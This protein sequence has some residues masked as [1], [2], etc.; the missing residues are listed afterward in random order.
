ML[1]RIAYGQILPIFERVICPSLDNG[2]VL[3]FHIFILCMC[4]AFT[5]DQC[6]ITRHGGT[7]EGINNQFIICRWPIP[8]PSTLRLLCLQGETE[9]FFFFLVISHSCR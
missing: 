8:H 4:F 6:S 3:S 2:E 5:D 7:Q 9:L 1:S